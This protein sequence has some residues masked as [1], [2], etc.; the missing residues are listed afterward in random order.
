M[1]KNLIT[2]LLLVC[3]LI[4]CKNNNSDNRPIRIAI[5]NELKYYPGEQLVDLYKSFFQGYWG[6]GHLIEDTT[7]AMNYLEYELQTVEKYDSIIY[8]PLGYYDKYLRLNLILV[9]E[10]FIPKEAYLNS[11]IESANSADKPTIEN[12]KKEWAKVLSVI[13]NE[14]YIFENFDKDKAKIDSLL[15]E[16]KYVV[17]HSKKFIETYNP[18]YRVISKEHFD[19][20][21]RKFLK[22]R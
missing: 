11:F 3:F 16:N 6:P 7:A 12:W 20:L 2:I 13:E 14:G 22:K 5:E 4:S 21:K 17:H 18:H 8:Q 9:K 15:A 19:K 1:N 10:G